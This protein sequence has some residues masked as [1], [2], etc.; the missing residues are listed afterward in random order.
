[1]LAID[2]GTGGPKVALVSADGTTVAWSSRPVATRF[3]NG[4]G[5]EQDPEEMWT[6]I[7]AATHAT[8]EATARPVP[9][10]VAVA[11]TSQYMSTVPVAANGM[12]T[13]P[14]V[15]W[16]D[17]RGAEHNLSLLTDESFALFVER[18]GLLPLPSGND[19][20]AHIHVLR[21]LHPE[22]YAA[23]AAFLEPM[24]Y[25]NARLTGTLGATQST[26]FGQMV[27]DNRTWGRT[28]YDAE[29]VS[30]T[31]LDPDKLAPLMPMNGIVG[32]VTTAAARELGIA[33]GL[34][35]TTGTI[36]SITSAIGSG[37]LTTRDA[38]IIVGTT[39]VVGAHIGEHRADLGAGIF[40]VP[41]PLSG[42]YCVMAE[43]GVGGRALEWAMRL[44]GYGE[45]YEAATSDALSVAAGAEG[46]EFMPWLLGSLA[47]QP[48]D[49]VRAA[50]TGLSLHH[51]RRH[52]VRA[53]ME[54]VA[55]NLA[56]LLPAVE[57]F[58]GHDFATMRFGGGGAQSDLWAQ[59]L[60]DA[61]DHPVHQMEDPRATNARGASFLAFSILGTLSI[62]DVPSL[63]RTRAI[64]QPDPGSRDGMDRALRR[65][66]ELHRA[67]ANLTNY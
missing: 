20:V 15:I 12:P 67:L 63:L 42:K 5:A 8:I 31:H 61:L 58:V 43:N 17:T 49:D 40:V 10:I 59:L 16:M 57:S 39:S 21:T 26:A 3:I 45:D 4:G 7:V 29:L 53:V 24:D 64:R 35:V 52:M 55:V 62:D 19:N 60:A 54:G 25:V 33:E 18:H 23:A 38:S 9:P 28:E 65:L 34:P 44:F 51:E 46:V 27:C 32:T 1:M 22:A 56:W 37:A 14:C 66:N 48:N 30:A 36:D 41:S 11:V 47:P 50:F 6:A 13:G 2:L